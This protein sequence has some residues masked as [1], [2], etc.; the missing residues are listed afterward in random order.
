MPKDKYRYY[1]DLVLMFDDFSFILS[2][3]DNM[4]EKTSNIKTISIIDIVVTADE[5]VNL[6]PSY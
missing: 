4:K 2:V 1:S 6:G 5:K 3:I